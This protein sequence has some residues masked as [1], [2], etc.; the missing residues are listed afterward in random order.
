[1]EDNWGPP[2]PGS[3]QRLS[4]DTHTHSQNSS[5][6]PPQAPVVST[7]RKRHRRHRSEE[8]RR[9]LCPRAWPREADDE[10]KEVRAAPGNPP[11]ASEGPSGRLRSGAGPLLRQGQARLE[12]TKKKQEDRRGSKKKQ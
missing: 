3:A 4:P 6:P 5:L 2:H 8:R 1:M 7:V 10:E 9:R 12:G 11:S